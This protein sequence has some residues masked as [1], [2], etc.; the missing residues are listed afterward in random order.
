MFIRQRPRRHHGLE[1][2]RTE[3]AWHPN[4]PMG[5]TYCFFD[6]CQAFNSKEKRA[7][8]FNDFV[9]NGECMERLSI[10]MKRRVLANKRKNA[11]YRPK[12]EQDLLDKYRNDTAYVQLL[13][14]DA[15]RRGR[16]QRDPLCPSDAS[17]TRYWVWGVHAE[18]L[19]APDRH[20]LES[21]HAG[22][23]QGPARCPNPLL[24]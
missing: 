20:W 16:V 17:K 11:L 4:G 10:S 18:Q 2:E 22:F 6:P 12:T 3:L 15:E 23:I 21:L 24:I 19:R 13:V 9:K 5:L 7:N 1:L 14:K 8:L